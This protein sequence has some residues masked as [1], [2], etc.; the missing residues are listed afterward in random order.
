M[1][2]LSYYWYGYESENDFLRY[3]DSPNCMY[4]IIKKKG[5]YELFDCRVG[6]NDDKTV[7]KRIP[8]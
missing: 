6:F 2:I 4:Y 7:I 8:K 1:R 3:M 5:H